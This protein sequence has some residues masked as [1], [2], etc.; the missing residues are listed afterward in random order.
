MM[1]P[2]KL[3]AIRA[4]EASPLGHKAQR[5]PATWVRLSRQRLQALAET[6]ARVSAAREGSVERLRRP[7]EDT[8]DALASCSAFPSTRVSRHTRQALRGA[9]LIIPLLRSHQLR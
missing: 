5:N 8:T 2:V 3:A 7:G 9:T 1:C 4:R 6:D